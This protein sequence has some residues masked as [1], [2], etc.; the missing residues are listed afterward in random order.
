MPRDCSLILSIDSLHGVKRRH[1]PASDQ[2]C[3]GRRSPTCCVHLLLKASSAAKS[4]PSSVARIFLNFES[5][6]QPRSKHILAKGRRCAPVYSPIKRN[7]CMLIA[8]LRYL[9]SFLSFLFQRLNMACR[10][11]SICFNRYFLSNPLLKKAI[12]LIR[13]KSRSP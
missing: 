11:A 9:I 13:R 1:S 4:P 7:C 3:G 2:Q 6:G 10:I 8:P 12:G 5:L